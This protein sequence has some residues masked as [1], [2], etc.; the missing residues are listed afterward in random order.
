[1]VSIVAAF[2]WSVPFSAMNDVRQREND[3]ERERER[4]S[5]LEGNEKHPEKYSHAVLQW[6]NLRATNFLDCN[7]CDP[8]EWEIKEWHVMLTTAVCAQILFN[9]INCRFVSC[10][11]HGYKQIH[12][13]IKV[14]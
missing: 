4:Q 10:L 9:I 3:R 14:C 2:Y 11:S 1:M 7:C 12:C 5:E 8:F 6:Q 13:Q